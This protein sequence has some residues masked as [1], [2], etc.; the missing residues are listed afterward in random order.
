MC[1]LQVGM[2][3]LPFWLPWLRGWAD[4]WCILWVGGTTAADTATAMQTN[5][6]VTTMARTGMEGNP[7]AVGIKSGQPNFPFYRYG[8]T[9]RFPGGHSSVNQLPGD[10]P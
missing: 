7:G 5:R 6:R 10:N 1:V 4:V 9:F 2:L 3:E 8:V